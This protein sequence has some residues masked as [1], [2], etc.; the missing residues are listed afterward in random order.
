MAIATYIRTQGLH[1][2]RSRL[3]GE[4]EWPALPDSEDPNTDPVREAVQEEDGYVTRR[5]QESLLAGGSASDD[6][7]QHA[8]L[9]VAQLI[10]HHSVGSRSATSERV[11]TPRDV[12]VDDRTALRMAQ[13][14]DYQ[15]AAEAD[16]AH[17]R[18]EAPVDLNVVRATRLRR[19]LQSP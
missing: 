5:T 16:E 1:V 10:S 17:Q 18:L 7:R 19:W 12:Q 11:V 15:R 13:D 8:A 2:L 14:D 4:S 3:A 9:L 6:A